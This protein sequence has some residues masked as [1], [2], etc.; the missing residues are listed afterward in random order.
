MYHQKILRFEAYFKTGIYNSPD[1]H[2]RVR[3]VFIYYY[4]EDDTMSIGEPKVPN[5]GFKQG[6]LVRRHRIPNPSKCGSYYSWKDLNVGI[7]L[8]EFNRELEIGDFLLYRRIYSPGR[9]YLAL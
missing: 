8:G 7:D 3:R 9:R 5:C 6:K 4:L 1:E 2:C